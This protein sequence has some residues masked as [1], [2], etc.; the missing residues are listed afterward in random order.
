MARDVIFYE[1]LTFN[2]YLET[3]AA[4]WDP[5]GG[6]AG[7]RAFASTEEE[8]DL[9]EQNIPDASAVAGPVPY[10]FIDM[11]MDDDNPRKSANAEA[12]YHF[13]DIGYITPD[14]VDTNVSE[15]VGPG[16]VPNP[17]V[18]DEASYPEDPTLP[19]YTKTGLQIL[20]LVAA[21]HPLS[22]SPVEEPKTVKRALQRPDREK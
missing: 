9:E 18:G 2:H 19:R 13:A 11:Q 3:I 1:N 15:R 6:F 10:C 17:E 14:N 7:A 21:V 4:N 8:A 5:S 20:G 12:Y 16:F 22:P